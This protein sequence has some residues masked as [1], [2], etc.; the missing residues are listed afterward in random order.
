MTERPMGPPPS[1]KALSPV[2]K[3]E[4]LT[5]CQP[6]ESGSTRAVLRGQ[7]ELDSSGI[8][9]CSSLTCYIKRHIVRDLD[10][11]VFWYDHKVGQSSSPACI[12]SVLSPILLAR[13]LTTQTHEAIVVT[14]VDQAFFARTTCPIVDDRL[15]AYAVSHSVAARDAL[16]DLLNCAAE[17]VSECQ[18]HCLA[19][20]RMWCSWAKR[21]AA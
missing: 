11:T 9:C 16:S 20:D 18:R 13:K 21:W 4:M 6:T 17:L 14:A 7:N 12:L 10:H 15:Y 5:A 8:K 19:G 1:T 2:W 3:G